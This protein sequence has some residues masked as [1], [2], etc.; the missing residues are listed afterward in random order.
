MFGILHS[1]CSAKYVEL[2]SYI[3]G[4]ELIL[5]INVLDRMFLA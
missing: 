1:V 2:F 4:A 5:S 3:Y